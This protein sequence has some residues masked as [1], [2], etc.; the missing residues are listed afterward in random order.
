MQRLVT[1]FV[2]GLLAAAAY[3]PAMAQATGTVT[4]QVTDQETGQPLGSVQVFAAGTNRNALTNSDGRFLLTNVP[5][6]ERTIR[7]VLIGYGQEEQT[8]TVT[9]GQTATVDLALRASAV[10]IDAV[11]VSVVTGRAE[12]RR[13]LGTNTASI[14]A[15]ELEFAPI[16]KMADVLVGRAAGVTMQG[17][18]GSIGTSQ[19]IRIRGANSISLSNEPLIF[20]DGIQV[21]NS[22]GGIAVG[23]QDYSRLNDINPEDI[24]NIEVLKG[25]A[26]SA[27][28]GTAAANGVLLITTRRG[29]AGNT[30]WRAYTEFGRSSDENEY[31]S[32]FMTVQEIDATAPL[33]LDF[34][35]INRS[36]YTYCANESAARGVCTQDRVVSLNPFETPG[37]NP[38]SD[39]NRQKYGL[40]VAGGG[41]VGTYYIAADYD[42]EQGVIDF[43]KQD[44]LALRANLNARVLDNMTV[45]INAA[46]TRSKLVLN[47]NDNNIFSP[48]INGLLASPFVPT[49]EQREVGQPGLRSGTGFG[50]YLSDIAEIATSQDVDRFMVGGNT[51]WEPLSWLALNANAGLDYFSRYD[52]ETLQPGRLPIGSPYDE[53]Y[54]DASRG[55]NYI[56]TMSAAGVATHQLTDAI[57]STT[58]LG[59]QFNRE[60]FESTGCFGAG[61]VEGT[62]S[63]SATSSLF[64]VS[65]SYTEVRTIGAYLQQQFGLN[66]RLFVT[67]SLRGDDNSAFGQD[68]GL[69]LYPSASISWVASEEP[70]FPEIDVISS[71]RLRG[72]VGVSGQRPGMRDAVTLLDPVAVT[73]GGSEASAVRLSRV[74]NPDLKPERTT[75][76]EIG[77]DMGLFSDRLGVDFAYYRK[78]SEDALIARPLP[79]SYGL[80]GDA[81]TTGSI[82]DNLGAIR[83]SG[84]ELALNARVYESRPF[85][86]DMRLSAS[87]LSNEIED[88]GGLEPIVFNRG[89]QRHQEGFSA[90]G[91]WGNRYEVRNTN[92]ALVSRDEVILTSDTA[93]FIGPSMPTNS[94]ALSADISLF[95]NLVRV[96]T[97]FERRAGH[98]QVN[99][100]EWFRCN[101]GYSRGSAGAS[102][103][104]GQCAGV[105]D[106]TASEFEQGRFIAGRLGA[107]NEATGTR[108]T[109]VLTGYI[110][111]ADFIKWRELSVTLGVPESLVRS[112]SALR[113][114]SVT[115]SGRNLTTWTDYTGIDP[116]INESGGG[117]NFTQGEFNTQPPL[118][119]YTV[120]VN[121]SF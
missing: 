99:Y 53:G 100:T 102:T 89:T 105:A 56:W 58:T 70:F 77:F 69:I 67:G 44:R 76:F 36:A 31:P 106:P 9:A 12:R 32:N 85:S 111:P 13:E 79:P 46:Y 3:T 38:F 57:A 74:G 101:T 116:E 95:N 54:R 17:V 22:K 6:G 47:A 34:G 114:L 43:N 63:C 94:Q 11:V 52:Y 18:A 2:A 45:G 117:A 93:V 68:F 62:R 121:Y 16:T 115:L 48:L 92:G 19:R 28:Y 66:D 42:T 20:V 82:W 25:P 7:A 30:Q 8:V 110:E 109:G 98:H 108:T 118:R 39:G 26:A 120:R 72:A 23:G 64:S 51:S 5:E 107:L 15:Q 80:T 91:F 119:Y 55:S 4:G 81:G 40:S 59:G 113:G 75:E 1:V 112:A 71:L 50:Y 103:G 65:E 14:S 61:I 41:D 73:V 90:G 83:N 35:Q 24:A 27:L 104:T 96:S 29:V 33:F 37:L 78:R 49:P 21:S 97:L 86:L 88:M 10:D 87:T 60:Q 84:T